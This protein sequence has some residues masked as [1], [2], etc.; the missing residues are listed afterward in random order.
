MKRFPHGEA[1]GLAGT[2]N[3]SAEVLTRSMIVFLWAG[4]AQAKNRPKLYP[5]AHSC[6]KERSSEQDN[7]R[8]APE[9][10]LCARHWAT[11]PTDVSSVSSHNPPLRSSHLSFKIIIIPIFQMRKFSLRDFSH[12]PMIKWLVSGWAGI[13]TQEHVAFFYHFFKVPTMCLALYQKLSILY[14]SKS[15]QSL[16]GRTDY[17]HFIG[18][19]VSESRNDF[20]TSRNH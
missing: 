19:W 7:E 5:S 18:T 2:I 6:S 11:G 3:K 20:T 15:S 14:L 10:L 4:L 17:P 12:L 13:Q 16:W 1:P 8:L 9:H